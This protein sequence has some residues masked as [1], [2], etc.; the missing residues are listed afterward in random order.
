MLIDDFGTMVV[1]KVRLL[2]KQ[3]VILDYTL[4]KLYLSC[5]SS[6]LVMSETSMC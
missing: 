2:Q 5:K 1:S 4:C 6:N 3:K